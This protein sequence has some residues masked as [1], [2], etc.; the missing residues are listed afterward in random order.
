[1]KMH[2][3]KERDLQKKSSDQSTVVEVEKVEK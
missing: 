2:F 1:M 3:F